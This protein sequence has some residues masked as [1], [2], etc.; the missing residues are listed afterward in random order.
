M[1]RLD[2]AL[3]GDNAWP[4]LA[5]KPVIDGRLAGVACLA[6]GMASGNPSVGLRV[7]LPDGQTVIAQTSLRLFLIAGRA[8]AERHGDPTVGDQP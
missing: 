6:D 3:D 1:M 4:D 8:I 5:G 2:I 7:E